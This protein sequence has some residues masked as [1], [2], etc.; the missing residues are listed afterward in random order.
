MSP[1]GWSR[2]TMIGRTNEWKSRCKVKCIFFQKWI[3][4]NVIVKRNN[5]WVSGFVLFFFSNRK[6]IFTTDLDKNPKISYWSYDFYTV[7][8][9]NIQTAYIKYRIIIINE[10]IGLTLK[11][12]C[13][14]DGSD[15]E[16]ICRHVSIQPCAWANCH[17]SMN[18]CFTSN[19]QGELK[20]WPSASW[21]GTSSPSSSVTLALKY[22]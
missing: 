1:L 2:A 8:M 12:F 15:S 14:P 11:A 17:T 21:N 18:D 13:S 4:Q 16:T 6:R 10:S 19:H 7:P 20:K 22:K 5:S 9:Q 3:V